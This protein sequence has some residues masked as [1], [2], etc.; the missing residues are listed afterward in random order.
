[1]CSKPHG[2]TRMRCFTLHGE[3]IDIDDISKL[4]S[5]LKV[6]F[7]CS[8]L[9]LIS[10]LWILLFMLMFTL[11]HHIMDFLLNSLHLCSA[12]NRLYESQK[13]LI[14]IGKQCYASLFHLPLWMLNGIRCCQVATQ[15]VTQQYHAFQAQGPPPMFYWVDGELLC[16]RGVWGEV[17]MGATPKT[18]H[19]KDKDRT[20]ATQGVQVTN[21]QAHTTT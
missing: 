5:I 10:V 4:H 14:A 19:V 12:I 21:P 9:E 8:L 11:A 6:T 20:R 15:T 3:R 13:L 17:G 18:Q 7:L 16:L 2:S 1:M